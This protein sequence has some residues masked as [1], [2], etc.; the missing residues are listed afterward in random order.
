MLNVAFYY[1][2]AEGHYVERHY[3]E[4]SCTKCHHAKCCVAGYTVARKELS[5]VKATFSDKWANLQ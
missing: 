3:A 5:M 2:Y 4:C 1:C